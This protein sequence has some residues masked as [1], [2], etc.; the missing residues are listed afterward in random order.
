[1]DLGIY[2]LNAI[3]HI[4]GEEPTDF[5]AIVSTRDRSGR[6]AEVEQSME[7]TMKFPSGV[8]A[9]CNTT[10]GAPMDGFYR[11]HGSLGVLH[12]EPAFPYQGLHLT[13]QFADPAGGKPIMLDEPNPNKDP[14]QFTTEAEYFSDCIVKDQSPKTGGEE[15]LL[16]MQYM[17]KI[18]ESCG[19]PSL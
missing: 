1:M 8:V 19:L 16:D 3:R 7:W 12:A 10:Y 14:S 17:S 5:T 13:A 15:G 9:S 18:Y 4:T 2:P 6:F 11:V